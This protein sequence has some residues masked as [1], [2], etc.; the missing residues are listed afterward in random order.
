MI[1]GG[2]RAGSKSHCVLGAASHR[3]AVYVERQGLGDRLLWRIRDAAVGVSQRRPRCLLDGV[4]E[5]SRH[6]KRNHGTRRAT[7]LRREGWGC[8][9]AGHIPDSLRVLM[10]PHYA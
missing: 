1:R 3:E 4:P 7:D 6:L 2:E 8:A 10:S 9:T 5:E